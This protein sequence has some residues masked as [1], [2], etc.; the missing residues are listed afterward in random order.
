MIVQARQH[1]LNGLVQNHHSIVELD[2]EGEE[3]AIKQFIVKTF[4]N[5]REKRKLHVKKK[6][7]LHYESLQFVE[8]EQYQPLLCENCISEL[9]DPSSR[10]YHDPFIHCSNCGINQYV[11]TSRCITCEQEYY[12][13][14]NKRYKLDSISCPSCGPKLHLYSSKKEVISCD[15]IFQQ[16]VAYLKQ[17]HI[18][19]V[20]DH[21][22]YYLC[23]DANNNQTVLTLRQHESQTSSFPVIAMDL[24][25]IQIQCEVSDEEKLQ[26]SKHQPELLKRR[27]DCSL[28][29]SLS[30]D[31]SSLHIKLPSTA[32]HYIL[33]DCKINYLVML[34]VSNIEIDENELFNFFN[35]VTKYYLI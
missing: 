34:K 29:Q 9:R 14:N 35:D 17:G 26:L 12:E 10:F 15:D 25:Y 20:K 8:K 33:L 23:C 24:D 4:M 30:D 21:D 16:A 1:Q 11:N 19:V 27:K 7:P 3:L 13:P 2:I 31:P 28:S 32:L 18:I 22:G 6:K 5:E